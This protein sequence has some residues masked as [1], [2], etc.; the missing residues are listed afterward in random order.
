MPAWINHS[1]IDWGRSESNGCQQKTNLLQRLEIWK[2][3][4]CKRSPNGWKM[5]GQKFH[6]KWLFVPSRNA[7][8]N[9]SEDHFAHDEDDII[10]CSSDTET[11]DMY[12]DV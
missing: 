7:A 3:L 11:D 1:R 6:L 8:M 4:T 5:C 2:K 10:D 12:P 9:G